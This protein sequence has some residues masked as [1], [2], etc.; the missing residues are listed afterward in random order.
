M[1]N[2]KDLLDHES[3][4]Y[5]LLHV[6]DYYGKHTPRKEWF[7]KDTKNKFIQKCF[8]I[9]SKANGIL[10]IGCGKGSF[11]DH[12]N[13]ILGV[14]I[15]GIDIS[16]VAIKS[17][18]D[19]NI[20]LASASNLPY[21]DKSFDVVYHFDGMEHIP[22]EIELQVMVEQIRVARKFI[23]HS[24]CTAPDLYHDPITKVENLGNA[25]VNLRS[26][27]EWKIFFENHCRAIGAKIIEFDTTFHEHVNLIIEL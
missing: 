18:P 9:L 17:R 21:L 1:T 22:T 25:H 5:N 12:F 27:T 24:I 11:I 2:I 19:L 7:M 20:K 6:R 10:D 23:I 4:K 3:K 16:E 15:E 14:K 26:N 8:S 13:S